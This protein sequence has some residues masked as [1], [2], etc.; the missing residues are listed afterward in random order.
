MAGKILTISILVSGREETTIKCLESLQPLLEELDSELILTDTGC[1][2]EFRE[3]L[4]AYTN[5]IYDFAWC[6]DFAK[7]RNLGLEA[8]NGEWFLFLDDDEWFDDVAPIVEFFKSGEYKEYE[9][10]VYLVR[11][12]TNLEGTQYTDEWVSRMMQRNADTHF[13]GKVHEALVPA[14]GKCKKLQAFVHHYGYAYQTKEEKV[15]HFRRNETLLLDLV[16]EEPNNLRW[17]LELLLE[18][19]GMEMGQ[20]LREEAMRALTLIVTNQEPFVNQ[21]RG[22]FYSAVLKG[23][24]LEKDMELLQEKATEYLADTRNTSGACAS[25]C[26]L[27]ARALHQ[28]EYLENAHEYCEKYF[29]FYEK[30]E[31]TVQTEQEQI[32]EE[33]ILFVKDEVTE[34]RYQEMCFLWARILIALEKADKLPLKQ[35]ET[36]QKA[37]Q[38]MLDGNGEFLYVPEQVWQLAINNILPFEEML[39]QLPLSQWM[40]LVMVLANNKD[41]SAWKEPVSKLNAIRTRDDI[42]YFYLDMHCANAMITG[43]KETSYDAMCEILSYFTESNLAYGKMVYTHVAFEGEMEALPESIRAAVYTEQ[44]LLTEAF[45][46][47]QKLEF[48]GKAAKVYPAIGNFIKCFAN[49]VGEE[50]KKQQE[51]A[52]GAQSELQ[53][54]AKEVK[55]QIAILLE[56]GMRKEAYQVVCQLRAMIPDDVELETLERELED[57]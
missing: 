36:V 10:A 24:M 1:K 46:W 34:N 45:D 39:L 12:Y 11:N 55:K 14:I 40:V 53:L 56:S 28:A 25:I 22:A 18:Y 35:R 27:A 13:E 44:L 31:Q 4:T 42:R 49:A 16:K 52:K 23:S 37:V 20:P 33:S 41:L 5:Q 54:M 32:I 15:A 57:E 9:Q 43:T 19:N 2:S 50:Q 30:K 26:A 7:A 8:A 21:C 6:D 47:R 38:A 3:K 48:A 17:R 51:Q 29:F